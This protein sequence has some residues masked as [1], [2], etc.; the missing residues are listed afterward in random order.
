MD[1]SAA[2]SVGAK[3]ASTG[4][5]IKLRNSEE[6][7]LRNVTA[8]ATGVTH[9]PAQQVDLWTYFGAGRT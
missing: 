7:I 2:G 9:L 4:K 3:K 8:I 1:G 5:A 6:F